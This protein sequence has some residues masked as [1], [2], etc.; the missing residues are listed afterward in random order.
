MILGNSTRARFTRLATAVAFCDGHHVRSGHNADRLKLSAGASPSGGRST[1]MSPSHIGADIARLPLAFEPNRGQ[2]ASQ[3][4]F[5]AHGPDFTLFLT[6]PDA[7]FS[8]SHGLGKRAVVARNGLRLPSTPRKDSIASLRFLGANPRPSMVGLDRLPGRVSY[9]VGKKAARWHTG[10]T[11]FARVLCVTST[12]ASTP[13]T[14]VA[15][16]GWST[17]WWSTHTPI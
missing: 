5:L 6:G 14:T 7:V 10:I 12:P 13:F 3:V 17:T 15:M 1:R 8:V 16:G 9:F 2:T 11:T 4:K